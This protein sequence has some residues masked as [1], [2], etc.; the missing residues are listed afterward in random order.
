MFAT[1]LIITGKPR[2]MARAIRLTLVYT[3]LLCINVYEQI[4]V[5][6]GGIFVIN[7]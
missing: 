6:Y 5:R 2:K 7:G 4:Y 3:K 1:I